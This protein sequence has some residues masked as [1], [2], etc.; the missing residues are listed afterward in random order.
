MP[1]PP[2]PPAL[3]GGRWQ[4]S[5]N[6]RQLMANRRPMADDQLQSLVGW[7]SAEVRGYRR[8]TI[9]MRR[10]IEDSPARWLVRYP[11]PTVPPPPT[12]TMTKALCQT[13]PPRSGPPATTWVLTRAV[14]K[15]PNVF[16]FAED[17]P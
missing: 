9:V 14:L 5:L 6:R 13:P 8:P 12:P 17:R 11:T 15:Q 7:R 4:E 10:G 3:G 16:F 2:P 1:P